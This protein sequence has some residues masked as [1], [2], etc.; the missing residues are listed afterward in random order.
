MHAVAVL[1]FIAATAAACSS[2][3]SP[4]T[5]ADAGADAAPIAP[6]PFC[7]SRPNLDF[8]EDFD[9]GSLPGHFTEKTELGGA[10]ALDGTTWAS[11]SR[12]LLAT[13]TTGA[14]ETRVVLS[15]A[16]AAGKKLRL[17][18]QV[19]VDKRGEQSISLTEIY[20]LSFAQ[21][22][23]TYRVGIAMS[24]NG[25]WSA[26]EEG[27]ASLPAATT[28]AASS[29]VPDKEWTSVRLDVDFEAT[30]KGTL[31]V[32]IGS[33]MV[34]EKAALRPPFIGQ[35]PMLSI[36]LRSSAPVTGEWRVRFDTI[37][38]QID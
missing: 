5:G 12:S 17:F 26:F 11:A 25:G 1:F 22:A 21:G 19:Y 4:D 18:G 8:C 31:S 6:E 20:A 34:V 14:G 9:E 16:F 10:L 37:N 28:F 29:G 33:D 7:A 30:G 35:G 27:A 3:V 23:D 32:K 24:G 36:G 38:L 2:S 15:K 13:A